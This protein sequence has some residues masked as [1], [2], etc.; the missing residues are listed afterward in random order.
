MNDVDLT[1][2]QLAHECRDAR[3]VAPGLAQFDRNVV[4]LDVA[5]LG[6]ASAE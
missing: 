6:K 3:N 5:R 2:D 1:A 4:S